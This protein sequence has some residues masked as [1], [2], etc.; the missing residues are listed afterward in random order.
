M[1]YE[2]VFKQL[3]SNFSDFLEKYGDQI[4]CAHGNI[5][6]NTKK[7]KRKKSNEEVADEERLNKAWQDLRLLWTTLSQA[8]LSPFLDFLIRWRLE[9]T[10]TPNQ[11]IHLCNWFV[12]ELLLSSYSSEHP[13]GSDPSTKL[14]VLQLLNLVFEQCQVYMST[15]STTASPPLLTTASSISS[16]S[17][18]SSSSSSAASSASSSSIDLSS[19]P[20][21]NSKSSPNLLNDKNSSEIAFQARVHQNWKQLLSYFGPEFLPQI[22]LR[23]E[24]EIESFTKS[25]PLSLQLEYCELFAH[26]SFTLST[27]EH[28]Q[29]AAM[30]LRLF[31]EQYLLQYISSAC[32]SSAKLGLPMT[33]STK[34]K[35]NM[36]RLRILDLVGK[37]LNQMHRETK[38]GRS[39]AA[40][41]AIPKLWY[42]TLQLYHDLVRKYSMK[43]STKKDKRMF[44][45]TWRVRILT[46]IAQ[47]L[48]YFDQ[49]HQLDIEQ[50]LTCYTYFLKSSS[51]TMVVLVLELLTNFLDATLRHRRR[52]HP[53]SSQQTMEIINL[54]HQA[55]FQNLPK[56]NLETYLPYFMEWIDCFC[57]FDPAYTLQHEILYAFFH[58]NQN[59]ES[60]KTYFG[61][62]ALVTYFRHQ[63]KHDQNWK[64]FAHH[65]HTAEIV[66]HLF[67]ECNSHYGEDLIPTSD[68]KHGR[69]KGTK[70]STNG[71][72]GA[73]EHMGW[74]I[75]EK[76]M[77]C[78][79]YCLE[80]MELSLDQIMII[81]SRCLIHA[82][83]KIREITLSVLQ[84]LVRQYPST[85]IRAIVKCLLTQFSSS[86]D[87]ETRS[88]TMLLESLGV[89]V[90]VSN[91]IDYDASVKRTMEAMCV[92]LLCAADRSLHVQAI[93]FLQNLHDDNSSSSAHDFNAMNVIEGVELELRPKFMISHPEQH[94]QCS[95]SSSCP[96][97]LQYL[98]QPEVQ[99]L[100]PDSITFQWSMYLAN[101]F[102]RMA[103]LCPEITKEAWYTMNEKE[104][105]LEPRIPTV[106]E[107]MIETC[108]WEQLAQWRNCAIFVCATATAAGPDSIHHDSVDLLLQRICRYLKGGSPNLRKSAILALAH[109]HPSA[110]VLLLDNLNK[111]EAEAFAN[112][113]SAEEVVGFF[114][115]LTL[116]SSSSSRRLSKQQKL[117]QYKISSKINLQWALGRCYRGVLE[118]LDHEV[119][120]SQP[121]IQRRLL[122]F[123]EHT[124]FRLALWKK[125]DLSGWSP[126][127]F[128]MQQDFCAMVQ[129]V[130]HQCNIQS[131]APFSSAESETASTAES[132]SPSMGEVSFLSQASRRQWFSTLLEWCAP[133]LNAVPDERITKISQDYYFKVFPDAFGIL[134]QASD[135]CPWFWTEE[136]LIPHS[137][138]SSS[139]ITNSSRLQDD[140]THLSSSLH[141]FMA[142]IAFPALSNLLNGPAFHLSM[143]EPN[144]C[145]F[146]WIDQVFAFRGD[147]QV[148]KVYAREGC[149]SFLQCNLDTLSIC[150]EKS[151][152]ERGH[153]SQH[154]IATQYF[155][156]IAQSMDAL[157][158]EIVNPVTLSKLVHLCLLHLCCVY[159]DETMTIIQAIQKNYYQTSD[160][161]ASFDEMLIISCAAAL[162]SDHDKIKS[163]LSRDEHS[164]PHYSHAN[165][166][167]D[168]MM[169]IIKER[170]GA[171]Q[172]DIST[173]LAQLLEH[174]SYDIVMETLHRILNSDTEVQ[175][176]MLHVLAPWMKQLD[177]QSFSEEETLELLQCLFQCTQQ[178]MGIHTNDLTTCW[179]ILAH[180]TRYPSN[181]SS[182]IRFLFVHPR[183]LTTCQLILYWLLSLPSDDH[184]QLTLESLMQC[185]SSPSS[186]FDSPSAPPQVGSPYHST[187]MSNVSRGIQLLSNCTR[188]HTAQSNVFFMVLHMTLTTLYT[189]LF[190]TSTGSPRKALP[191]SCLSNTLRQDC[192]QVLTHLFPVKQTHDDDHS[193]PHLDSNKENSIQYWLLQLPHQHQ[194]VEEDEVKII[195]V[196]DSLVQNIIT[197][198]SLPHQLQSKSK[199]RSATSQWSH[200]CAKWFTT[201][202][203]P[204]QHRLFGRYSIKIYRLVMNYA[205]GGTFDGSMC[206]RI[207]RLLNQSLDDVHAD[208]RFLDEMLHT[209]H[210]MMQ[211]MPSHEL[212]LYPQLFWACITI[213]SRTTEALHYPALLVLDEMWKKPNFYQ[214]NIQDVLLATRPKQYQHQGLSV[215]SILLRAWYRLPTTALAQS[216]LSQMILAPS[217]RM[218]DSVLTSTADHNPILYTMVVLPTLLSSSLANS[219]RDSSLRTTHATIGSV[220]ELWTDLGHLWRTRGEKQLSTIFFTFYQQQAQ[221]Q[222]HSSEEPPHEFDFLTVFIPIWMKYL[223]SAKDRVDFAFHIMLEYLRSGHDDQA[224]TQGINTTTTHRLMLQLLQAMIAHLKLTSELLAPQSKLS[225]A[226]MTQLQSMSFDHEDNALF[227]QVVATLVKAC[228]RKGD[229]SSR[230]ESQR[231]TSGPQR[232]PL[233]SLGHPLKQQLPLSSHTTNEAAAIVAHYA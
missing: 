190:P 151:Q 150:L 78:V 120:Q 162:A 6:M 42:N 185:I 146:Q 187:I 231:A 94:Y 56:Q 77:E 220:D 65:S 63:E 217:S 55:C 35:K 32:T 179:T 137:G 233:P 86:D 2:D 28:Y 116:A 41:V 21:E 92:Q 43:V 114:Q 165:T 201:S 131:V 222:A 84:R 208:D 210:A 39:P 157:Q 57:Y 229:L 66:G 198:Q 93:S 214:S 75:F 15:G 174:V 62:H 25:T 200:E 13:I 209:L 147:Y 164:N 138:S 67:M 227:L 159:S 11:S 168:R 61:I 1:F 139:S 53:L 72:R 195:V 54:L 122:A 103:E 97:L 109:T 7:K 40:V 8:A 115:T 100:E 125:Q 154:N 9:M 224:L 68:C 183:D 161:D 87:Q 112:T 132:A 52:H 23:C 107:S 36:V 173:S 225:T 166:T 3:R 26:I 81:C 58:H 223:N 135:R 98:A 180:S 49:M 178:L 163:E 113:D 203:A 118:N 191:K 82:S 134:D 156:V 141:Y 50:L 172:Y 70:S 88:V 4:L 205:S 101:V 123:V 95:S 73:I 47:D 24:K 46:V 96:F 19:K 130:I 142:R 45:A 171:F 106:G 10:C 105:S 89:I 38:H 215:V 181:L 124:H 219:D 206:L 22:H 167:N 218:A 188:I 108:S 76:V 228:A 90:N 48:N 221:T 199:C 121:A 117:K 44:E 99:K 202:G 85:G 182:V 119:W 79:P 133:F 74:I 177:F 27:S 128:M 129:A 230:M 60:Q 102:S 5:L 211:H 111:Y 153:V 186:S 194:V 33:S 59:I 152:F 207:L 12:S 16:S 30:F 158:D 126:I 140:L 232:Q 20:K 160:D 91:G 193:N 226:L 110:H 170:L 34:K 184:F 213:L 80:V 197:H 17:S 145:V 143:L 51:T 148:L 136:V 64:E 169:M 29:N 189:S 155:E 149:Q 18:V 212:A 69:A 83:P 196:V 127:L 144:S 104:I 31:Y 192:A 37:L 14:A 71:A 175:S 176:K 204:P 216:I